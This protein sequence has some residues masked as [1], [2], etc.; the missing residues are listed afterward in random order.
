MVV[1]NDVFY[2]Q[3]QACCRGID[4]TS[5]SVLSI[6]IKTR[7]VER[8]RGGMAYPV[9]PMG[10]GKTRRT[11]SHDHDASNSLL[12]TAVATLVF[13]LCREYTIATA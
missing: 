13:S 9:K 7:F 2:D 1:S 12:P 5:E 6:R 4:P 8:E 3:L 10:V 11:T